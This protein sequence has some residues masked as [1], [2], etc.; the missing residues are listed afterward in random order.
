MPAVIVDISRARAAG[1]SPQV[2]FE[3][4]V[5]DVWREWSASPVGAAR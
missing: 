4:G 1:W 3:D 5:A 2:H